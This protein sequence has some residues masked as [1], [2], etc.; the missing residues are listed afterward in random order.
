MKGTS[1]EPES[2][3]NIDERS[4]K[5]LELFKAIEGKALEDYPV[6]PLT[7]WLNG[8]I[9][10]SDRGDVTVEHVVRPEMA[11]PTGL[12]HGG[13]QCAMLDDVIGMMTAT[14][15]YKGFLLSIDLNVSYLGKVRVGETVIARG[16]VTREGR[17]IVHAEAELKTIDGTI[18]A[19]ASSNLLKT[20]HEPDYVK[21]L[22]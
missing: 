5:I 2:Q 17:N 11:N 4:S 1:N 9:I 16:H 14:L 10:T 8:K 19:L 7:K 3:A 21:Q 6:P 20:S 12:L 13:M 15:G 22:S 18:V